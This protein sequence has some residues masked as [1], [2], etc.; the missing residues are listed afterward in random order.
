MAAGEAVH[1]MVG[2][3]P[4]LIQDA[5]RETGDFV[6]DSAVALHDLRNADA[7]IMKEETDE[8]LKMMTSKEQDPRPEDEKH[9]EASK[10]A[11]ESAAVAVTQ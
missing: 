5:M 3:P 9:A 11:V 10:P 4:K 6:K 2:E 7:S 8:L 1:A